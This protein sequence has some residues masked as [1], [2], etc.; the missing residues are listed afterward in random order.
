MC[1]WF[2]LLVVNC[3]GYVVHVIG[4]FLLWWNCDTTILQQPYK[5][6]DCLTNTLEYLIFPELLQTSQLSGQ[7]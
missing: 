7:T 5:S 1:V 2:S 4:A 3:G 6:N